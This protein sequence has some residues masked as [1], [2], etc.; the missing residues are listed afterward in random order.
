MA[1]RLGDRRTF[2]FTLEGMIMAINVCNSTQLGRDH[3]KNQGMSDKYL[4]DLLINERRRC[5]TAIVSA[6][7]SSFK[8]RIMKQ[9]Q[10]SNGYAADGS[11]GHDNQDN[12]KQHEE[13][14]HQQ[15]QQ[16]PDTDDTTNA[17]EQY[18]L[19]NVYIANINDADAIAMYND[20]PT[21]G[22]WS[23]VEELNDFAF[24]ELLAEQ[25]VQ[26][27]VDI[28]KNA[29]AIERPCTTWM[30]IPCLPMIDAP[31]DNGEE[32][33]RCEVTTALMQSYHQSKADYEKA[34]EDEDITMKTFWS[35]RCNG[36]RKNEGM[37]LLDLSAIAAGGFAIIIEDILIDF[38][39]VVATMFKNSRT[40][41]SD[42]IS[43]IP[44]FDTKKFVHRVLNI[45]TRHLPARFLG[46]DDTIELIDKLSA[47]LM[48]DESHRVGL[49]AILT[50]C[51]NGDMSQCVVVKPRQ[52]LYGRNT[53]DMLLQVEREMKS[54]PGARPISFVYLVGNRDSWTRGSNE[55]FKIGQ[56]YDILRR[57]CSMNT[58][59]PDDHVVIAI[60]PSFD[61]RADE[62]EVF[63]H[64]AAQRYRRRREYFWG[65]N[66]QYTM[67][68]QDIKH[69][70]MEQFKS[71]K[72]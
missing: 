67:Y 70:T 4:I 60:A 33:E 68:F 55:L 41:A 38:V 61:S 42:A 71:L 57:L 54:S 6:V 11:D 29:F 72:R 12:N 8:E 5:Y 66:V 17:S 65:P 23:S 19:N 30:P 25:A 64:F 7:A 24:R 45:N 36:G 56:T 44:D 46:F 53:S 32:G 49:T 48:R 26:N 59:S 40:A 47:C 1:Y 39:A 13:D 69:R 52:K 2:C 10:D 51:S 27:M 34:A 20:A 37:Q 50:R 3:Y 22:E 31:R 63:K 18:E 62:T 28:D 16:Q 14:C 21:T 15:R 35:T 43:T 58:H 9:G